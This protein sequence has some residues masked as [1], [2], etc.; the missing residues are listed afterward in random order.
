[1]VATLIRIGNYN[2]FQTRLYVCFPHESSIESFPGHPLASISSYVNN[3]D[4][5]EELARV[6]VIFFM[7]LLGIL[8]QNPHM[9]SAQ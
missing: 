3:D 6:D 1:M 4:G 9:P 5:E 2:F 8:P 7:G